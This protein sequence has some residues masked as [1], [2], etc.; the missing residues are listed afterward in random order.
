[1]L[2]LGSMPGVASLRA[3]AY[4]AHPRNAFWPIMGALFGADPALPYDQRVQCLM[5]Q[6]IAVWD[7]LQRCQRRGSLDADIVPGSV[8]TNDF[9]TLLRAHPRLR[10]IFFNGAAAETAFCR[11]VLPTLLPLPLPASALQLTRLPSTSPAHAARSLAEKTA[12]WQVIR[13]VLD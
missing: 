12:D 7:V 1:V 10:A 13:D 8:V 9:P 5:A 4:Y 3:T 2:I 6:G 11:H